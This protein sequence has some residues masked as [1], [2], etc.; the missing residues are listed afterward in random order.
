MMR[1]DF[2]DPSGNETIYI[3]NGQQ[4]KS[5][6]YS[7]GEWT[8]LSAVYTMQFNSWN[9][10]WQGYV[11]SLAAWT[12]LGDYT[13]SAG[14]STVRIYNISVNPTLADSLFVHS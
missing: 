2:F 9:T 13:Y 8:D 4:Q 7:D 1:I 12:G 11:N 3:V 6:S 10:L 14:G 5:W